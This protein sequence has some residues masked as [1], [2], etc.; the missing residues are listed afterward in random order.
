MNVSRDNRI[1]CYNCGTPS[2]TGV[3]SCA[4]CHAAY[5]YNCPHCHAWVDISVSN[6]ASCG[7][8]LNWPKEAYYAENIYRPGKSSP[9]AILLLLSFI[10]LLIVAVN[11]IM[12]T[13]NPVD[14]GSHTPVVAASNS[15]PA[16]ELK[17]AA[18]PEIQVY[19][20]APASTPVT[21]GDASDCYAEAY[22]DTAEGS[23]VYEITNST[24]AP[25]TTA[26]TYVPK[27]SSYLKMMYP[28]WGNCSGGSCSG[29]YQYGQ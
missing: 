25:V 4:N 23:I 14:A 16:D 22:G 11:L 18:Q 28:N 15:I 21:Q 3:R 10:V 2:V 8:K 13:T 24:L 7:N 9:A 27:P 17:T 12:N 20:A 19:S 1:A 29:Y 6:C 5:Y 26:G